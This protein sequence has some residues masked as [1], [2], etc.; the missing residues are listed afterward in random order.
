MITS[1]LIKYLDVLLYDRNLIGNLRLSSEIFGNLRKIPEKMFGNVRFSLG[2]ILENLR[3]SAG[4]GRRSSKNRQKAS[5]RD[6][7]TSA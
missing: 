1:F 4:N 6:A 3:K 7:I 2:T 5:K